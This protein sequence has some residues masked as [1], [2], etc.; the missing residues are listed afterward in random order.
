MTKS[1]NL[2]EINLKLNGRFKTNTYCKD[3]EKYVQLLFIPKVTEENK[4]LR[5]LQ[6]FFQK[7]N[8]STIVNNLFYTYINI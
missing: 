1:I 8:N 4:K 2:P 7:L 3:D 6:N 5:F